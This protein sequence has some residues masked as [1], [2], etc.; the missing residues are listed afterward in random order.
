MKTE[1]YQYF[2]NPLY[3]VVIG[4]GL[5]VRTVLAYLDGRYR[6]PQLDRKRVV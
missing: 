2:K 5:A 6:G 3:W 4:L 1:C